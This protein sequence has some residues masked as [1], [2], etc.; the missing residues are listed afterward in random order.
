[1]TI[2]TPPA[3]YSIG[4]VRFGSSAKKEC[5]IVLRSFE[6]SPVSGLSKL[7]NV[8]CET[9]FGPIIDLPAHQIT[10]RL[11]TIRY[12]ATEIEAMSAVIRGFNCQGPQQYELSRSGTPN[13][14]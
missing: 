3:L 6:T 5:S 11:T 8:C 4:S 14:L 9:N 1:M 13:I 2:S 7:G 12:R 10:R